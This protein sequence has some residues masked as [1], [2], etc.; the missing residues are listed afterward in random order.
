ML[1]VH[2]EPAV[3]GFA[4]PPERTGT[5]TDRKV[6]GSQPDPGYVAAYAG[7]RVGQSASFGGPSERV[8]RNGCCHGRCHRGRRRACRCPVRRL[9]PGI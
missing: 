4:G 9:L 5:S 8:G 7:V 1:A 3:R 2:Q 6:Q